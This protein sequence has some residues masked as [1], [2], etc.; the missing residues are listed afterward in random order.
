MTTFSDYIAAFRSAPKP[1]SDYTACRVAVLSCGT[2]TKLDQI[3][4][5]TLWENKINAEIYLSPYMGHLSD[6][7]D[8]GGALYRFNP[9]IIFIH[10]D[11][12]DLIGDRLLNPYASDIAADIN[13]GF[14]K[15]KAL[16]LF[17]ASKVSATI[18]FSNYA[19][20]V[21]S[22]LGINEKIYFRALRRVNEDLL[23]LSE[24]NPKIKIFDF[25]AFTSLIGKKNIVDLKLY[26]EGDFRVRPNLFPALASEYAKYILLK[27]G[28]GKKAIV[29]DLDN[30]I[31][32]GVI[33]EDGINGVELSPNGAGRPCYDFQKQLAALRASGIVLA[34]SSRNNEADAWEMFEKHPH[35]VLK[36]EDFAAYRINWNDKAQSIKEL[37]QELSLGVDSMIFIDD[38]PTNRDRARKE[39]PSLFVPDLPSDPLY[40]PS[41]VASLPPFGTLDFTAEDAMRGAMYQAERKRQ[42]LAETLNYDDYIASLQISIKITGITQENIIRAAQLTQKTN[43]FN[44]T[45]KRYGAGDIEQMIKNGAILLAAYVSDRFGESGLTGVAIAVSQDDYWE[46]DSFLLSCRVIG[47]KA[48]EALLRS[49]FKR[50]KDKG[51]TMVKAKIIFTP[52]NLPARDFYQRMGFKLVKAEED[53]EEYSTNDFDVKCPEYIKIEEVL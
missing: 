13:G 4:S 9:E 44:M 30:T 43:Q 25:E 36:K 24:A 42:E 20:P 52:K 14:E 46:I 18:V 49:L 37:S 6:I 29:I 2:I 21:Y 3:L 26:Y 1:P 19:I 23:Y 33:G 5:V 45:T 41:I 47:K 11:I 12:L 35:M 15:I 28:M 32:G 7:A 51:A 16:L 31:W 40:Y 38:D 50:I 34:I 53:Y 22:P 10:T 39:L 27:L 17:L 8:A 48:E